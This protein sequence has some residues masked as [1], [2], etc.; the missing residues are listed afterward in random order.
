MHNRC[1][2]T[3]SRNRRVHLALTQA[4]LLRN[5]DRKNLSG[6]RGLVPIQKRWREK[7]KFSM[8]T[9]DKLSF[10][11]PHSVSLCTAGFVLS[12]GHMNLQDSIHFPSI[13]LELLIRKKTKHKQPQKN[14][15]MQAGCY[16][17]VV[18]LYVLAL[19]K[20]FT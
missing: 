8:E 12:L 2:W 7:K 9:T 14:R 6:S 17:Y 10:Y 15:S 4:N 16:L 20:L 18:N 19:E 1:I 11:L 5:L 3:V 13:F